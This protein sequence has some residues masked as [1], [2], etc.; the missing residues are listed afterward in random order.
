MR[1]FL[2]HEDDDGTWIA[3][4]RELPGFQAKAKTQEEALQKI[5]AVLKIYYPC[6]CED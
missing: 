3:E 2:V 6:R 1:E 4:A 5:Q